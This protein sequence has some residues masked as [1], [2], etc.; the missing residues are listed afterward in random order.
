M[1]LNYERILI[2]VFWDDVTAADLELFEF[3]FDL[4]M[5]I[6]GVYVEIDGSD[7]KGDLTAFLAQ[8]VDDFAYQV[9]LVCGYEFGGD[10]NCST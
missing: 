8:D 1:V 4:M 3:I 7:G 6:G 2:L 10:A 5:K 9:I